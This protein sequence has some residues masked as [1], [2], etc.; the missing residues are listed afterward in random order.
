MST[1]FRELQ[2]NGGKWEWMWRYREVGGR[3]GK[4]SEGIQTG[5]RIWRGGGEDEE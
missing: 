1:G 2:V 4:S 5:R 3:G